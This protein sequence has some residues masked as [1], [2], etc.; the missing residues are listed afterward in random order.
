MDDDDDP[1]LGDNSPKKIDLDLNRN[2]KIHS[3]IGNGSESNTKSSDLSSTTL[4]TPKR[5][6]GRPKRL[7]FPNT[8]DDVILPKR[9]C[10][11][12][13][14][15]TNAQIKELEERILELNNQLVRS[16]KEKYIVK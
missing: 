4:I 9:S 3:N 11:L 8:P 15:I 7:I 16:K 12:K 1:N 2:Q 10:T 6:R 13:N 5:G 14:A